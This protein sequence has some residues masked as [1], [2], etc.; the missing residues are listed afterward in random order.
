MVLQAPKRPTNPRLGG[1]FGCTGRHGDL[2]KG[3]SVEVREL[4]GGELGR[5]KRL[6]CGSQRFVAPRARIARNEGFGEV[7]HDRLASH[8]LPT[9]R[10][11]HLTSAAA[12]FL[13]H[14]V[15]G[16]TSSDRHQE[17]A[18][19]SSRL[20]DDRR[21]APEVHE[22]LLRDILRR[23]W[24]DHDATRRSEDEVRV[25]LVYRGQCAFIISAKPLGEARVVF[26][27][28]HGGGHDSTV[29][30]ALDRPLSGD[31]PIADGHTRRCSG[32]GQHRPNVVGEGAES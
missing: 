32:T 14:V 11:S 7:R 8:R 31:C 3:V 16:P 23:L 29:P 22:D 20:I 19:P 17:R 4:N 6:E 13:T 27:K 15:D 30:I 28:R 1:T 12:L 2:A 25:P 26:G 9:A 10:R 21:V 24:I 18:K 5:R